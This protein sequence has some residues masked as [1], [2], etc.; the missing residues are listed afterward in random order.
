[1]NQLRVIL[2]TEKANLLASG[3]LIGLLVFALFG[4]EGQTV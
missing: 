3:F 2:K 1:V 4:R